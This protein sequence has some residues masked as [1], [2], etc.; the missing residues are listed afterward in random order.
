MLNILIAESDKELKK[1][2]NDVFS[3]YAKCKFVSDGMEAV[4]S[5]K[6]SMGKG[7][8]YDLII[9]RHDLNLMNGIQIIKTLR[10]LEKSMNVFGKTKAIVVLEL[11][12]VAELMRF[13]STSYEKC[14]SLPID[15]GKLMRVLKD[16]RLP[17]NIENNSFL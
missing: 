1:I 7:T 16:L 10:K 12:E 6:L 14:I 15:E 9:V 11:P 8:F 17:I 2:F 4:E 13:F 5:I 3:N